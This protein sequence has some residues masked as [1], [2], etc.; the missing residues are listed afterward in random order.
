MSD[1]HPAGNHLLPDYAVMEV[2]VADLRQLFNRMDPSPFRERDLDPSAEEFIIGWAQ[3]VPAGKPLALVVHLE[4]SA[5]SADEPAVIRD[6][7]RDFFRH[8]SDRATRRLR[9]LFQRGRISLG[10][11]MLFLFAL[12][13]I[14]DVVASVLTGSRFVDVLREGLIIGGWVAM[15]RPLEIFLY[16]WWPIRGQIRLYDRLASMPVR[17][18][19][20]SEP[21]RR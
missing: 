2:R 14:G 21:P 20:S 6:A 18:V 3:T 17:I 8:E 9:Q 4:R 10:I 12:F 16:D 19:Y 5:E 1:A 15:W 7:I 11:A 13:G